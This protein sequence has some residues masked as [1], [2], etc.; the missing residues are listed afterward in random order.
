[1][2]TF[3]EREGLGSSLN[4]SRVLQCWL[5]YG[6]SGHGWGS[7]VDD[8]LWERFAIECPPGNHSLSESVEPY[9]MKHGDMMIGL[10]VHVYI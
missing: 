1:M 8:V 6:V 7:G 9:M 5:Y 4:T 2:S 3:A 10:V